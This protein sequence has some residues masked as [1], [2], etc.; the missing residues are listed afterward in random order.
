MSKSVKKAEIVKATTHEDFHEIEKRDEA[1][2]LKEIQGTMLDEFV[3]SFQSGG[4][5]VTGLSWA[6]VKETAR[7]M[8]SV[9]VVDLEIT[10]MGDFWM[11]TAKAIDLETRL[12]VYGVST[13]TKMMQLKDGKVVLD[14]FAV[15][16]CVS[17]AQRNAIRSVIPEIFIAEMLE[18]KKSKK[19][20]RKAPATKPKTTKTV[21]GAD[22][23][24]PSTTT[25]NKSPP[26]EE[27]EKEV[28][29]ENEAILNYKT[30][31]ISK[32][33]LEFCENGID[34]ST[35]LGKLVAQGF[36]KAG[37]KTV[38]NMLLTDGF[39]FHDHDGKFRLI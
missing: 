38:I 28:T 33:I 5:K 16:K 36:E 12:A 37:I 23:K 32:K 39:L 3:Y 30:S 24:S 10:D 13:Q 17:K 21:G 1:Q 7:K 4:R 25:T 35:L 22:E 18:A 29:A 19:T 9:Q 14:N 26:P 2:I 11:A 15:Q 6:G 27:T 31:P 20:P 8:G 34:E